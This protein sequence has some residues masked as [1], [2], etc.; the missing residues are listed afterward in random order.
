MVGAL[1]TV[2][3][4]IDCVQRGMFVTCDS[5]IGIFP[6]TFLWKIFN[7][8]F[9]LST[10]FNELKKIIKRFLGKKIKTFIFI[11]ETIRIHCTK[12]LNL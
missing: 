9:L 11:C 3:C 2:E 7:V 12:P 1:P 5:L 10:F 8:N 4:L 6:M